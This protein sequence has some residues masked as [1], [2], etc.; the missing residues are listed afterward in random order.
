MMEHWFFLCIHLIFVIDRIESPY[1]VV[2]W[3][4]SGAFSDIEQRLLP[5]DAAEGDAW[6]LHLRPKRPGI[7]P[8][9]SSKTDV[10]PTATPMWLPDAA[11]PSN[12]KTYRYRFSR[13]SF[14][15]TR[16]WR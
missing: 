2:E 11:M 6:M 12:H 16:S 14:Q 3:A 13:F 5:E 10:S 15:Q 4:D 1:A 9:N 7:P 8:T